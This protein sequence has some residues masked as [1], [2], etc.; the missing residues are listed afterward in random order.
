MLYNDLYINVNVDLNK[1]ELNSNSLRFLPTT[2]TKYSACVQFSTKIEREP[3]IKQ[4]LKIKNSRW[5]PKNNACT[6]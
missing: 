4:S 3:K 5:R 1:K 2:L 6:Y